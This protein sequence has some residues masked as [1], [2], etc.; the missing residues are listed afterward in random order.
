[1]EKGRSKVIFKTSSRTDGST[2]TDGTKHHRTNSLLGDKKKASAILPVDTRDEDMQGEDDVR[3]TL[4]FLRLS[5]LTDS[6]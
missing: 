1:M 4:N 2:N 3:L 6:F 5:F